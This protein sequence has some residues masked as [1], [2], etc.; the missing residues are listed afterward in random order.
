MILTVFGDQLCLQIFKRV[1]EFLEEF[2][3]QK[4]FRT[5]EILVG[6]YGQNIFQEK[7][8]IKKIETKIFAENNFSQKTSFLVKKICEK[9]KFL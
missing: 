3:F 2:F 6:F 7:K 5:K 4:K 1:K 8:F 9:K